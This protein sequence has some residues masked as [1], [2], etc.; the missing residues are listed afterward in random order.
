MELS[1]LA[2]G[3]AALAKACPKSVC[4]SHKVFHVS[5]QRAK[6][7]VSDVLDAWV[8]LDSC[9]MRRIR[10]CKSAGS[11]L[12]V[13]LDQMLTLEQESQLFSGTLFRFFVVAAPLRMVFPK[14]VPFFPG[15]LNNRNATRVLHPKRWL[16][17]HSKA[18]RGLGFACGKHADLAHQH[19]PADS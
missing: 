10:V 8:E 14:R 7:D 18:R 15:L 11:D 9:I 3:S 13:P 5:G 19:S 4:T 16:T 1:R 6:I 12:R 2:E 17:K